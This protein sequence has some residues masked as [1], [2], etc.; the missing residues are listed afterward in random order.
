MIDQN[1]ITGIIL[2]GGK[3]SRMGTDKGFLKLE[4]VTFVERIM[5]SISPFVDNIIIVSDNPD[6]NTFGYRR[7]DD[8]IKNSG[9]LAG[10][11]S[12][13]YYSETEYNLVLSCDVPLVNST[14]LTKLIDEFDEDKDVVQLSSQNKTIPLV[15]FYKKHCMHRCLELLEKGEKRLRVALNHLDTKTIEVDSNMKHLVRNINTKDQLND[16]QHAVEH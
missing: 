7:V 12:G 10:L 16:I 8:I 9:P 14:I 15:A 13:L 4:G 5:K 1:N 3:S 6:Y 11:Y 2:A